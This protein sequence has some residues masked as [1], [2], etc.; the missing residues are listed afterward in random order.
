MSRDQGPTDC[1]TYACTQAHNCPIRCNL[2]STD[3]GQQVD[4]DTDLDSVYGWV[5]SLIVGA[6]FLAFFVSA[7]CVVMLFICLF[8]LFY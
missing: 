2:H 7:T 1:C 5:D 8:Q 6:R 3:C 4:T